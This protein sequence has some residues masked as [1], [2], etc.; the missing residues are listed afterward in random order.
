M[1]DQTFIVGKCATCK[2]SVWLCGAQLNDV[3][4]NEDD[5]VKECQ[6]YEGNYN[7]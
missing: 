7:S 2:F 1:S 6:V 3:E 4:F 5:T